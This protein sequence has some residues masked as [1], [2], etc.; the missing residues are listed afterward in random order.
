MQSVR[1]TV[2]KRIAKLE[3]CNAPVNAMSEVLLGEIHT[4]LNELQTREDWQVLLITSSLPVFCAGGD[5]DTM[6]TW[7]N[8]P[9]GG[10]GVGRYA[11]EVQ[12]L[13]A[14]IEALAQVTIAQCE[15][16]TLGGGLEL[17]LSC[18]L[19]IA[20]AKA[21]FGLPEVRLGLLPGAGGTQRLTRLCG[22][23]LASRLI[24]GAEVLDAAK[25][26]ELGIVQ[27]VFSPE[28]ID[29]RSDV[30]L[31]RLASMPHEAQMQAKACITFAVTPLS[32]AGFELE[33]SGLTALANMTQTKERITN[34]LAGT[35]E[36]AS[37]GNQ[38]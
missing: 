22:K 1:L 37:R 12:K 27:W 26:L 14:R 35:R 18:D 15:G 30:L 2:A 7:M 38:Q 19:R 32:A 31:T 16:A 34:F 11:H 25:A 24:L 21:K 33:I 23:A 5:L 6:L 28:E 13:G 3:L 36:V 20:S 9:E 4:A 8:G 29:E 17:A 10:A